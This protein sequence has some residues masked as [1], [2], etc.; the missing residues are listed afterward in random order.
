MPPRGCG[1]GPWAWYQSTLVIHYLPILQVAYDEAD[2]ATSTFSGTVARNK[3]VDY[4]L[5]VLVLPADRWQCLRPQK[6]IPYYNLVLIFAPEIWILLAV[7]VGCLTATLALASGLGTQYGVGTHD[8]VL[9]AM[10]AA[11]SLSINCS[12][13]LLPD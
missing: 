3:M 2:L 10:V 4:S 1:R 12:T 9:V 7:T 13:S 8:W 6:L 11:R 5:A